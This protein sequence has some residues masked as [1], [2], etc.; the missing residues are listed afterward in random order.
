M[1]YGQLLV[2]VALGWIVFA[3][4]PD[5]TALLGAAIIVGAGLYLWYVSRQPK[6]VEEIA[7]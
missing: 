1:T 3:E 6:D 2:A 7:P 4:A 5:L